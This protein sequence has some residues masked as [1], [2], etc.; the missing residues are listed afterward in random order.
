MIFLCLLLINKQKSWS[1]AKEELSFDSG[2]QFGILIYYYNYFNCPGRQSSSK[3]KEDLSFDSG[4]D[5]LPGIDQSP[6]QTPSSRQASAGQTPGTRQTSG[7]PSRRR[8]Q[9]TDGD[10]FGDD[11]GLLGMF[12]LKHVYWPLLI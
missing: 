3:P 4:D 2:E 5:L 6:R 7:T 9:K 1:K 12:H 11:D 8:E 10:L